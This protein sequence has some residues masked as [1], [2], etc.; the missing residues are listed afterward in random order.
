[1]FNKDELIAI[2]LSP[3]YSQET[4]KMAAESLYNL[5]RFEGCR[6]IAASVTAAFDA[7]A[8]V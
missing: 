8:A 5:G 3:E 2:L 6:Y 1:M 7:K 4:K